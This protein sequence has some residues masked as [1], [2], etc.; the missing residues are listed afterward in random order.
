M[1]RLLSIAL[2]G[3]IGAILRYVVS[4]F[5]YRY[6]NGNFPWG[7]LSANLVGALIIGLLWGVS[8]EI[9]IPPSLRLFVFVGVIGSFT[10]FS[11]YS[12]ETF[13]LF[14]DGEIKLALTNIL[15]SNILS[16]VLVFVGFIVSKNLI[17]LT[18]RR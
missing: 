1:A 3:A 13:N 14:R 16:I 4:G 12:L 11:T 7:T 15:I 18:G 10:T 2:G 8:E 5:T 6:L 9:I 17:I